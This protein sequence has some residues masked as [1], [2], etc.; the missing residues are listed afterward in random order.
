MKS[1][2]SSKFQSVVSDSLKKAA[3]ALTIDKDPSCAL[4]K[5]GLDFVSCIFDCLVKEPIEYFNQNAPA[6]IKTF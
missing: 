3:I 1:K 2:D 6:K 4:V 5:F